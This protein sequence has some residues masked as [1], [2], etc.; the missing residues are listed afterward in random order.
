MQHTG[1]RR[2]ETKKHAILQN[3]SIG[4]LSNMSFIQKTL[5]PPKKLCKKKPCNAAALKWLLP[6]QLISLKFSDHI[7]KITWV[8]IYISST[9]N[10]SL[11]LSAWSHVFR[12]SPIP[13]SN[14]AQA[15]KNNKKEDF[16]L[17]IKNE[18]K[19]VYRGKKSDPAVTVRRELMR[20][21]SLGTF[22]LPTRAVLR[23]GAK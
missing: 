19:I 11:T 10:Q 3:R 14:S 9:E 8:N 1:L 22:I 17:K 2:K 15:R 23:R 6:K 12:P 4:C 16:F 13:S 18:K 20:G 21:F 5:S 7:I